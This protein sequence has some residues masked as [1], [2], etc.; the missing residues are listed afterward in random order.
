MSE[1]KV[2]IRRLGF[3]LR[4]FALFSLILCII[5]F[6]F[7]EPVSFYL[8]GAGFVGLLIAALVYFRKSM[9]EVYLFNKKDNYHGFTSLQ[10]PFIG[11]GESHQ[12]LTEILIEQIVRISVYRQHV[13]KVGSLLPEQII[14]QRNYRKLLHIDSMNYNLACIY[15]IRYQCK[16][17]F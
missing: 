9:D 7:I 12:P 1:G 3:G 14:R 17:V 16:I 4:I 13:Y 5:A 8:P 11:V 15:N 2:K 6:N 10:N